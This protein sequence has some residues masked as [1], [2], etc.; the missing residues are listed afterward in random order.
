MAKK[1]ITLGD[2]VYGP[3]KCNSTYRTDT[4]CHDHRFIHPA[5][6][7]YVEFTAPLPEYFENSRDIET[8]RLNI[9]N[10]R[11]CFSG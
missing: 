10:V 11:C 1:D 2:N 9:R 6:G 5:T 7:K 8:A 4:A 3:E